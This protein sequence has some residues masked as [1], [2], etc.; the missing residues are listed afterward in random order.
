ME[1][2]KIRA[3]LA[4]WRTRSESFDKA[5]KDVDRLED[6]G[7]RLPDASPRLREDHGQTGH[8]G[9]VEELPT[10]HPER[11]TQNATRLPV[12]GSMSAL[13]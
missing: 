1:P 2:E 13:P 4:K 9:I 7:A 5:I 3:L 8:Y 11:S 6:A 10:I 12:Q